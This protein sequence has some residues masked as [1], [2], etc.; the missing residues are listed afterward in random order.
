MRYIALLVH[1]SVCTESTDLVL[2]VGLYQSN[3]TIL[4][5]TSSPI[6]CTRMM[7]RMKAFPNVR[8]QFSTLD[9]HTHLLNVH[10]IFD[11]VFDFGLV[12]ELKPSLRKSQ[13]MYHS[14]HENS[15]DEENALFKLTGRTGSR[16]Y[17]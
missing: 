17:M 7:K 8:I 12:K 4:V 1:F 13:P 16:R 15:Y 2:T 5:S 3:Q 11:L 9:V 6:A 10:C 14:S